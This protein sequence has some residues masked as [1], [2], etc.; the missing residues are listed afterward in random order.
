MP[1]LAPTVGQTRNAVLDASELMT[2][3]L[4]IPESS[5]IDLASDYH[6]EMCRE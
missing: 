6:A 1:L 4:S 5:C 2:E 3:V